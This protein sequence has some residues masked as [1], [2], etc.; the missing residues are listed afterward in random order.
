MGRP[1]NIVHHTIRTKIRPAAKASINI[2]N[3]FDFSCGSDACAKILNRSISYPIVGAA[4]VL[5]SVLLLYACTSVPVGHPRP[6]AVQ[7]SDTGTTDIKGSTHLNE[8]QTPSADLLIEGVAADSAAE[9]SS[10]RTQ[11]T[12]SWDALPGW[13][14]ESMDEVWTSL[15]QSCE[16]PAAMMKH[17]CPQM[18]LLALSNE[19]EQRSFLMSHLQP[20][21]IQ[22]VN[23]ES[24]GLLT[25]YYE[26]VFSASR[27]KKQG[28]EVPLYAPSPEI[29][30]LKSNHSKWYTRR[31]I[32]SSPSVQQLLSGR[33]IAWL[34][35]PLDA[36]VLQIQ[37]SGRL[38]LTL[39]NGTH[40][41][42]KIVYAASN[43]QPYQ[44]IGRTLIDHGELRDASWAGIRAWMKKNPDRIRSV[45]W[46]NPR[47]VFFKE[48]ALSGIDVGPKGAQGLPLIAGRSVA[49]DP[50]FIAYGTPLWLVS[51]GPTLVLHK[52]VLAQDTGSAISGALRADYF[53]GT[54]DAAGEVAG[55]LKQTMNLW[56]LLPK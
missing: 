17:L 29:M 30:A 54:G 48:E 43:E 19:Q 56:A 25:G 41:W 2:K 27:I 32:E 55:R 26:P 46:S 21:R 16:K 36:L 44:S 22:A 53:V 47:Y 8:S 7:N 6:G 5:S 4:V 49:V 13:G 14:T 31:E 3:M 9:A 52:M 42:I 23:S 1:V 40:Q 34:A 20:Y 11:S 35:D 24:Q 15:L 28:Y 37:G 33:E 39:E 38:D 45:L 10:H 51:E 18:R 50:Q 12:T